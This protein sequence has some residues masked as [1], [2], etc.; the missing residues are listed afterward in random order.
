MN[1]REIDLNKRYLRSNCKGKSAEMMAIEM[2]KKVSQIR[3]WAREMNL[4]FD[5]ND[6]EG[7][8][9]AVY[10]N[11]KSPYGIYDEMKEGRV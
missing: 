1:Q 10:S 7:R 6:S 4:H 8:P 9:P 5:S 3:K 2:K 11:S